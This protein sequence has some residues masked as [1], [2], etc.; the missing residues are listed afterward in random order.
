MRIA[1]IGLSY[2]TFYD[3]LHLAGK[4]SNDISS[5]PNPILE[6]PWGLMILYDEL[7]FLCESLCPNNMRKL[8][9]VKFVDQMFSDLKINNIENDESNVYPYDYSEKVSYDNVMD[10]MKLDFSIR[11]G[12]DVHTHELRIASLS[13]NAKD[14]I[15]NYFI[16]MQVM[17][18]LKKR[19]KE[20]IS[21]ISN[22]FYKYDLK[23]ESKETFI[24]NGIIVADIDNYIWSEGPYHPCIEEL[25]EHRYLKDF[26]KWVQEKHYT[27]Q[28]KESEE[29]CEYVN[30]IISEKQEDLFKKYLEKNN[31]RNLFKSCS[32]MVINT[33]LGIPFAAV[34]ILGAGKEIIN[35]FDEKRQADKCRWM[36]FVVD[37]QKIVG[38]KNN[39]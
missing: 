24:A 25:R 16:D 19:T 5:S 15:K 29:M 26:R 28:K 4:T 2:P 11:K 38:R 3:Y 22:S 36:G 1:Y 6:S 13:V 37:A 12:L 34:S 32:E 8:P 33:A 17:K 14:D 21:L 27:L 35:I 30:N 31:R 9:Y 39:I 18:E 23:N 10:K 7:W 20:D